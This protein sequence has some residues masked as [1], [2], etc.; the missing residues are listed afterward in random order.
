MC[1]RALDGFVEILTS[2]VGAS[3]QVKSELYPK[4]LTTIGNLARFESGLM[5]L[6]VNARD[7]MPE[8]GILRFAPKKCS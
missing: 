6:A 7:A 2:T 4:Q 1:T 3:I 5:N 8:G